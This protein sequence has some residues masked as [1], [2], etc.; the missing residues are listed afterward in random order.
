MEKIKKTKSRDVGDL[1]RL[2]N[3]Y[4]GQLK[5][6]NIWTQHSLNYIRLTS[7]DEDTQEWQKI[8]PRLSHTILSQVYIDVMETDNEYC[9]SESQQKAGLGQES[10][11]FCRICGKE[12][13]EHSFWQ[14]E[15]TK[16]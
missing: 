7:L 1:V 14:S 16:Q 8:S 12:M 13:Y 15:I 5:R 11:L 3:H 6:G 4:W 9:H 10:L 2:H